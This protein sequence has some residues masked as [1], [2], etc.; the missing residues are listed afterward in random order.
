MHAFY[1]KT[2]L[3]DRF[4]FQ[5]A[6]N[7]TKGLVTI[8]TKN[9]LI[10]ISATAAQYASLA[11]VFATLGQSASAFEMLNN[12]NAYNNHEIGAGRLAYRLTGET[13]SLLSDMLAIRW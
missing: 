1:P 10:R 11:K 9:G 7:Q 12:I 3:A 6:A 5:L 8:T 13:A 4:I 2:N